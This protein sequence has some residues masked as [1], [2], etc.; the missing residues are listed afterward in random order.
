MKVDFN[1][2]QREFAAYIRNPEANP[3]P[4]DVAEQRMAMYRELF[5]NN[6]ENF[7][8]SNFP[9]IRKLLDDQQWQA[10]AQDFF[11]NHACE[12]PY[13]SE[14]P[15]EFIDFLQQERSHPDDFPFLVELAHYEWVEMAL[16][17]AKE[18]LVVNSLPIA[19]LST[20]SLQVSP[21]AWPL[22]YQYQV[23][24]IA[25]NFL[26]LTP[27][28]SATFLIVY[29][30]LHYEVGFLEITPMTY[31]LL[32]IIQEQPTA[33]ASEVLAQIIAEMQHPQP[34]LIIDGGLQILNGLAEKN[35]ITV[36]E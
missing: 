4:A 9:V 31:R 32:A 13:F 27:P 21:L 16:S 18:E 6:I 1:A 14:I 33:V 23:H 15:E 36:I 7:L 8:S 26:P 34:Q 22:A 5:F 10:L 20:K 24:K 11:V 28:E 29:R 2:K 12:S 25:P 19:D 17:I 3:A 30:D 35:I